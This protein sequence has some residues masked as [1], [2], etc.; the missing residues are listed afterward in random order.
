MVR[1]FVVLAALF[2]LVLAQ[3]AAAAEGHVTGTVAFRDAGAVP[4]DAVLQVLLADVSNGTSA[5]ARALG[6]A[7]VGPLGTPPYRFDIAFD[8]S[9]IRPQGTYVLRAELSSGGQVLYRSRG[10]LPVLTRGA[11][12]RATLWLARLQAPDD[13]AATRLAL[14]ASFDGAMPCPDCSSVRFRLDLW[15]D[16]VFHLRRTWEGKDMRRDAIGHWSL[17]PAT[18]MLTLH[19]GEDDLDFL[20]LDPDHLRQLPAPGTAPDGDRILT[21]S[22]VFDP[23]DPELALRGLVTWSDDRAI[24]EECMTGRRYPVANDGDYQSLEHAYLAAGVEPGLP[25]MASFDGEIVQGPQPSAP[26]EVRV[27]RFVGVWPGETCDRASSPATLRNTYWR[28]LRLGHAEVAATPN[29]REPS[30]ILK[31][32]ER[33][34]SATV[35]CNPLT[36]R[37]RLADGSLSFGQV[38][39]PRLDCPAPLTALETQLLDAL[40]ATR[41][42]QISGQSLELLDERGECLALLQAVYLY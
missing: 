3:A 13:T 17:D 26:G 6:E 22:P 19:G 5:T 30:L 41:A 8:T 9:E 32:G 2:V 34:F 20:V 29:R 7:T 16:R 15:P 23:F 21:A 35:G 37:F 28:I 27:E 14:P 31:E 12:S 1:A 11:P 42:W 10:L 24:L 4:A 18:R 40:A 25:L 33:R 39:A 36:G 38:T